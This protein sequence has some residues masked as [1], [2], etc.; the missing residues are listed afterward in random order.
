METHARSVPATQ[1]LTWSM[2]A[3]AAEAAEEAPR[4]SM[5][6]APRLP[7]LGRNSFSIQAW[8]STTPAV[9]RDVGR[10]V[11]GDQAVGVGGV[12]DDE[13]LDVRGGNGVQGLALDREYLTVG[14]QQLGPLHALGA[15]AGTDEQRDVGPVE[16]V[17]GMIVEVEAG[18]QR[19]GA[20]DQLHGH[21]LEGAHRL[22]DLEQAQIDGLLGTEKLSAG[23]AKDDAVADLSGCAGDGHSYW[24]AH[25]IFIS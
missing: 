3:L 24:I 22:G 9:T 14:A 7:T 15:R 13:H 12:A 19:K 5:T 6:A 18:K 20:V 21:A 8:S 23:D 25:E 4:A 1:S 2:A 17:G 16:G 11:H 10:V